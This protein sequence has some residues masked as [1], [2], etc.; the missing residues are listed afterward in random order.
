MP[1]M[2]KTDFGG[3]K[4]TNKYCFHCTDNDGNLKSFDSKIEDMTLFVTNR[5]N[6]VGH[7]ARTLAIESLLDMPA[8]KNMKSVYSHKIKEFAI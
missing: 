6:V 2:K 5:L 1:M 3:E 7:E 4:N 8:W